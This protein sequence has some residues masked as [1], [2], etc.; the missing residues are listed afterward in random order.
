MSSDLIQVR[1]GTRVELPLLADGEQGYVQ[2]EE[3]LYI[4]TISGNVKTTSKSEVKE[5]NTTLINHSQRIA[6]SEQDIIDVNI[7]LNNDKHF[8]NTMQTELNKKVDKVV[9]SSLMT[10]AE[11]NKLYNIEENANNYIHPSTHPASMIV[12]DTSHRFSTDIEKSNWDDADSKKH[13]HTNKSSID[14]ITDNA[15]TNWNDS[16]DKKH[17]HSNKNIIDSLNKDSNGNLIFE[18]GKI[19]STTVNGLADNISIEAGNNITITKDITNNKIVVSSA[20]SNSGV[21]ITNT[22]IP[23]NSTNWVQDTSTT[24][25][26]YNVTI[27]HNLGVEYVLVDI[28]DNSKKAELI[29]INII[30]N[31]SIK[32]INDTAID[33]VVVINASTSPTEIV[34]DLVSSNSDKALSARQGKILKDLFDGKSGDIKVGTDLASSTSISLFLKLD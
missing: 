8:A 27:S 10:D 15:I 9:G 2:D 6:K 18:G 22:T 30:D 16:N 28:Y 20:N 24:P 19:V 11:H 25:Y 4:G 17:I 3:E 26:T 12:E 32:L 1:R 21:I 33:C 23:I 34:D 31:N 13:T 7:S 29:G 5:M 14:V